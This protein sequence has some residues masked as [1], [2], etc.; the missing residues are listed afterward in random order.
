VQYGLP[1]VASASQ[2]RKLFVPGSPIGQQHATVR[3][4]RYATARTG[5]GAGGANGRGAG[6]E[7][8]TAGR[9]TGGRITGVAMGAATAGGGS[10]ADKGGKVG[11]TTR[12]GAGGRAGPAAPSRRIGEGRAGKLSRCAFP[13]TAFLDTF[14]RRPISAVER[15]SAHNARKRAMLSSFHSISW[16]PC[17]PATIYG[18]DV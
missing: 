1:W 17:Y 18:S 14:M 10:L 11:P 5:G 13:T 6:A 12:R 4:D 15:P 2:K 16:S 9:S 7:A 3:L 8:V